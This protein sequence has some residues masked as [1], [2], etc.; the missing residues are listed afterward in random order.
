[1]NA[2]ELVRRESRLNAS[3]G[4]VVSALINK[5]QRDPDLVAVLFA[6]QLIPKDSTHA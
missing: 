5:Q 3:Q 1:M 4:L 6:S 2:R